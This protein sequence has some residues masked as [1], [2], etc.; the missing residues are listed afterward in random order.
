MSYRVVS[1]I[2]DLAEAKKDHA[3]KRAIRDGRDATYA[4]LRVV[5]AL[6]LMSENE[7]K[8]LDARRVS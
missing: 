2:L 7:E 5:I 3:R 8:R 4:R 1:R 6:V